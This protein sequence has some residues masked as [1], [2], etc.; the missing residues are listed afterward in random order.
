MQVVLVSLGPS[1]C[2]TKTH[3]KPAK[4]TLSQNYLI[5]RMN[6]FLMTVYRG[7]TQKQKLGL[8]VGPPGGCDDLAFSLVGGGGGSSTARITYC[9]P[10]I[11]TT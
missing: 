7:K 3:Q 1:V 2:L 9:W 6:L 4:K 5:A 10:K 11:S 8:L